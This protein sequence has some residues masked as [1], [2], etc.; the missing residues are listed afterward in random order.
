[1]M[2]II[3]LIILIITLI[4]I[5]NYTYNKWD[6]MQPAFILRASSASSSHVVWTA[7]QASVWYDML[8]LDHAILNIVFAQTALLNSRYTVVH[9]PYGIIF[10]ITIPV[11]QYRLDHCSCSDAIT[12]LTLY[13][14]CILMHIH[15]SIRL[16]SD[17]IQPHIPLLR[18]TFIH[19]NTYDWWRCTQ[20][21]QYSI[22]Y[23][24]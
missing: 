6:C 15:Y 12:Q 22:V 2:I 19:I 9:I 16:N 23:S 7:C 18:L 4:C 13:I 11:K 17:I 3:I 21:W 20:R 24:I 8:S 10:S 14:I 5:Y 1:M